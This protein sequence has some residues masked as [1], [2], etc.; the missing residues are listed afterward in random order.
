MTRDQIE[1]RDF[2]YVQIFWSQPHH[3]ENVVADVRRHR[4]RLT[5]AGVHCLERRR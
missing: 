3:V 5:A 2:T 1:K 4:E